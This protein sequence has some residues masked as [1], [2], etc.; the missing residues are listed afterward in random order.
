MSISKPEHEKRK[1]LYNKG[2]NDKQIAEK[3]GLGVSAITEW[4]KRSNLPANNRP[5]KKIP[6]KEHQK[7]LKYYNL[8]MNDRQIGEKVGLSKEGIYHWRKRNDLPAN[9]KP[10]SKISNK[11]HQKR[12]ELY[13]KGLTDEQIA[14]K[15][16]ISKY[17]IRSWRYR[18]NLPSNYYGRKKQNLKE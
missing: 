18:N 13:N 7:R 16:E 2:L 4:R 17:G 12:M 11:K 5:N 3:I 9:D 15:V 8:G 10:F 6:E 1:K 14:E